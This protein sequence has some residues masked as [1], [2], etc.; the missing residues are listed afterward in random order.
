MN[1]F[2]QSFN[3]ANL[4]FEVRQK[5]LKNCTKE[6]IDLIKSQFRNLSGIVYCLS[7]N[8]CDTLA[9]ELTAA[10]LPARAY[11]AGMTDVTRKKVQES[12]IQEDNFKI[13]CATIAF[14]MG[15]DKPDVRYVI[16]YSIPKSIEGYY[17]EAGRAGR[18]G[19]PATCI[20]YYNWRDVIRLRK[21]IQCKF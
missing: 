8:E 4:K 3:R 5:R 16:H 9:D 20:L 18:D 12:W 2:I 1:K 7:R 14:G 19:L 11:H 17:Q 13:V 6:I 21:L 15:I 10:G